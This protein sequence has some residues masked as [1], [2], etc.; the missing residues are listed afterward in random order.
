MTTDTLPLERAAAL[1]I[2]VVAI[3]AAAFLALTW[4]D[5]AAHRSCEQL[6]GTVVGSFT[7]PDWRCVIPTSTR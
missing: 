2:A 3:L 6:G 5:H 7:G 4:N 1:F